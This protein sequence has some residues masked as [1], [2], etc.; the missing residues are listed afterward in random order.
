[1]T[2]EPDLITTS[3]RENLAIADRIGFLESDLMKPPFLGIGEDTRAVSM[4]IH[5]LKITICIIRGTIDLYRQAKA[6]GTEDAV[7]ERGAKLVVSPVECQVL[8]WRRG[9]HLEWK[10][11][12][13]LQLMRLEMRV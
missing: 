3:G 2:G 8:A 7:L 4:S 10:R 9:G 6:R 11:V 13:K 12:R 1:M 5:D